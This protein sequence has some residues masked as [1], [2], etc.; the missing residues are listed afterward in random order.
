MNRAEVTRALANGE[1]VLAKSKSGELFGWH[2]TEGIQRFKNGAWVNAQIF[3]NEIPFTAVPSQPIPGWEEC[4]WEEAL[5]MGVDLTGNPVRASLG[6]TAFS[7]V[8]F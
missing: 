6:S 2:D 5:Q 7:E 4:S 1:I 8:F 3:N